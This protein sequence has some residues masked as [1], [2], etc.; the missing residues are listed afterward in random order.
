MFTTGFLNMLDQAETRLLIVDDESP[1]MK[2]LCDT[3]RDHGYETVGFTSGSEALAALRA[4]KFD[5]LLADLMMPEMDGITLL[6]AALEID[7]DLVGII[8]TG[9]GTVDTAVQSMKTGALD[10][11][12]KPFKLSAILPTPLADYECGIG[13]KCARACGSS[14]E[15]QS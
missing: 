1:Q 4:G 10:Y 9:Q 12:L 11:I 2:A 8:M 13:A 14:R 5:L 7:S 15:R 6:S 3:L